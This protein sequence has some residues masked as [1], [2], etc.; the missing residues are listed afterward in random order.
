MVQENL[1][2]RRLVTAS[3]CFCWWFQRTPVCLLP[4][5]PSAVCFSLLLL[6]VEGLDI[7]VEGIVGSTGLELKSDPGVP[8]V[9]SGFG[10]LMIT[11]LISYI[12][13]SQ[14]GQGRGLL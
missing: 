13:H 3:A 10:A 14:V 9:Y 12:S 8:L 7:V 4:V 1:K 6:Q 11:T 5:C 2:N